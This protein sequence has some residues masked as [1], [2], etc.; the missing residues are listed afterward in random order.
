MQHI[1]SAFGLRLGTNVP[2]R[3]L[4]PVP[5]DFPHDLHVWLGAVPGWIEHL[6]EPVQTIW[7]TSSYRNDQGHPLLRIWTLRDGAYLRLQFD[8]GTQFILDRSGT[9]VWATWPEP[10]TLEDATT[11][12][13]GPI[14][15]LVL[16]L[17]GF[18]TLHASAI[19]VDGGAIAF[20]GPQ[21]HHP[22]DDGV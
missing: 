4:M 7:Y 11:Y 18:V 19:S 13:L 15:G 2:L 8:D 6:P 12:L 14:I 5:A 20:L 3:N 16:R 9:E 22:G 17:R 10:L 1:Y 21:G